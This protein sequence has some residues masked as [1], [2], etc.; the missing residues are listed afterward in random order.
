MRWDDISGAVR[1]WPSKKGVL[2]CPA[3]QIREQLEAQ[4]SPGEPVGHRLRWQPWRR[5]VLHRSL[6]PH[7]T[8]VLTPGP[9]DRLLCLKSQTCV[10]TWC[11]PVVNG[12]RQLP[13]KK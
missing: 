4:C 5:G 2:A 8:A 11:C 7:G 10:S 9:K 3:I 6:E 13:R 12:M 1:R